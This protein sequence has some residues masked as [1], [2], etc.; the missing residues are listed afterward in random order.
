M[1]NAEIQWKKSLSPL[2]QKYYPTHECPHEEKTQ[3]EIGRRPRTHIPLE[4][5]TPKGTSRTT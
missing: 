2:S 3:H 1:I 5:A 4:E